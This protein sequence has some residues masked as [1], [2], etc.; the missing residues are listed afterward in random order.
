[1][2]S[3]SPSP[4]PLSRL[5]TRHRDLWQVVIQEHH[6]ASS[7]HIG[8]LPAIVNAASRSLHVAGSCNRMPLTCRLKGRTLPGGCA[9]F[10]SPRAH[11]RLCAALASS[12]SSACDCEKREFPE[13]N[14]FREFEIFQIESSCVEIF[15]VKISRFESSHVEIS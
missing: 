1:M 10:G 12:L 6:P 15:P 14:F 11:H 5:P 2:E 9:L 3:S 7:L 8:R 4:T 13:K